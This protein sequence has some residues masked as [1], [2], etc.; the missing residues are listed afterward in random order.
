MDSAWSRLPGH[1][2]TPGQAPWPCGHPGRLRPLPQSLPGSQVKGQIRVFLSV[3]AALQC[4]YLRA[5]AGHSPANEECVRS[6]FRFRPLRF[7]PFRSRP[8]LPRFP[9]PGIYPS[10][11]TPSAAPSPRWL[12]PQRKPRQTG[13]S[14]GPGTGN[15][16]PQSW[17]VCPASMHS[18][19]RG[20]R[21]GTPDGIWPWVGAQPVIP[22]FYK[23]RDIGPFNLFFMTA[24]A[25]IIL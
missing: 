18:F 17:R 22:C 20:P 25:A 24:R 1:L 2:L 11:F 10:S 19:T 23:G 6:A 8:F 7:Q 21:Y 16:C 12:P 9:L 15:P 3:L 14:C 5:A 4:E 13:W